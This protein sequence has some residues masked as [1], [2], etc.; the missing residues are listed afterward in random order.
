MSHSDVP[1]WGIH[2]G[3][4]GEGDDLFLNK[5]CIAIGWIEIG[6]RKSVV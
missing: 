3:T 2:A 6:D 1:I 5:N 4:S